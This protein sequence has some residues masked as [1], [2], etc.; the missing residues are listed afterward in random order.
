M[1]DNDCITVNEE[2]PVAL[3]PFERNRFFYGKLMT[4]RDFK[5]EQDYFNKK[6]YLLNRLIHGVGLV[7]GGVVDGDA[8]EDAACFVIENNEIWLKSPKG[9]VA[10]DC[11]G[12]EIIVPP[13]A[14]KRVKKI[15]SDSNT[16]SPATLADLHDKTP[17][18]V[19]LKYKTCLK[20][21]VP[22]LSNASTCEQK[23]CYS[24]TKEDVEAILCS[25]DRSISGK[26]CSEKGDAIPGARVEALRGG[27]VEATAISGP[28]WM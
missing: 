13:G 23:C 24:R 19:F 22:S 15:A 16:Y 20:D 21:P 26:I 6:R 14:E 17:S 18:Y 4:V 28:E 10:L 3:H 2:K 12:R 7:C 9:I 8:G 27:V 11:W 25:A 5:L 1:A